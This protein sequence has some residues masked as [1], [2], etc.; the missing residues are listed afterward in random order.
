MCFL[1]QTPQVNALTIAALPD[2]QTQAGLE[3]AIANPNLLVVRPGVEAAIDVTGIAAAG[4]VDVRAA[5]QQK[6]QTL[7]L[8]PADNADVRFVASESTA[9]RFP[10]TPRGGSTSTIFV[11][12][13]PPSTPHGRR[14]SRSAIRR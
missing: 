13:R 6:L 11:A 1:P 14:R 4:Q 7:G 12:P 8:T 3:R 9:F 10:P 5:L 2:S